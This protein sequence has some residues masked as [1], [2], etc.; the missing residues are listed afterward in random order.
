MPSISN[1]ICVK[2]E[3]E[4]RP[5]KNG[6][7]VEEHSDHDKPYKIWE[8][9]LWA[10]LHCGIEIIAGFGQNPAAEHY[11]EGYNK[12]LPHVKYHIRERDKEKE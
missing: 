4:M 7:I 12:L 1:Y 6:I 10:C 5:K 3:R 9:D 8:A 11:M 2:C